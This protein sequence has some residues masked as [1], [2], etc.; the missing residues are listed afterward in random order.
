MSFDFNLDPF[1]NFLNSFQEAQLKSK[2]LLVSDC[3]A[4][5]LTT[6]ENNKPSIRTVLFKG[7]I[8]RGFSFF[9]HYDSRKGSQALNNPSVALNF[10]W[11]YLGH[12]IGIQGI[13]EKISESQSDSYFQT[14]SRLSQIGAWASDQSQTL[15][16]RRELDEKIK[17]YENKFKDQDVPRPAEW[18]G[19]S[20]KPLE[21]EFW[22][23]AEGRLH[24]RYVYE[25]KNLESE[26]GRKMRYP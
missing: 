22:F 13:A 20:V 15:I 6:V 23:L 2:Q 1:Q 26:W 9:T 4:M 14:R 19:F 10:F 18:G 7:L 24:Q 8:D 21:I 17:F 5:T 12:Q 16:D 25:R 3:N 11:P